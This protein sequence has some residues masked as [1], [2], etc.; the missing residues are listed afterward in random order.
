MYASYFLGAGRLIMTNLLLTALWPALNPYL[1]TAI[2]VMLYLPL[3]PM[4]FRYSRV[5][6]MHI[7]TVAFLPPERED[8]TSDRRDLCEKG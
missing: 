6:W 5:I 4:I 3:I 1:A 7:D 8:P 2:A